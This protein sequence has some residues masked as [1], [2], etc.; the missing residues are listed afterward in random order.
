MEKELTKLGFNKEEA[1]VYISLLESGQTTAGPIVKKTGLHRQVVYDTLE[2]L[3][4]K[5]LVCEAIKSNRKNWTASSPAQIMQQIK[6]QENLAKE[7]LPDLFSAYKLSGH[8]QEVRVFEGIDGFRA[9]H[10][11]NI[12]DQPRNSEVMIMGSTGWQWTRNMEK[13]HFLDQFEKIR[14][15]KNM[16]FNIIFFEKERKETE[17]LIKEFWLKQPKAQRR[18]YRFLPDYFESPVGMQIWEDNIT[19]IIYSETIL[20]I[21]IKNE[22]VVEN[23]KKYFEFLWK[24]A[25]K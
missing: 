9:I 8:K 4:N 2:K 13:S 5:E 17:K 20:A 22:L 14:M 12:E 25:K 1:K 19:M 24:I 15:S 23:F 11:N 3:K 6:K 18:T 10:K 21:Q 7:I 16:K